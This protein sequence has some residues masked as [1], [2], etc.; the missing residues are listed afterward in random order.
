MIVQKDDNT[1][2]LYKWWQENNKQEEKH[3]KIESERAS[4]RKS[5]YVVYFKLFS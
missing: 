2:I 5:G 4:E 1:G 3:M